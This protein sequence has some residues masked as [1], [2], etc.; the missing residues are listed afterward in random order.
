MYIEW[1]F[2]YK[3][4]EV[5]EVLP[6]F[7]RCQKTHTAHITWSSQWATTAV[8]LATGECSTLGEPDREAVTNSLSAAES[9]LYDKQNETRDMTMTLQC[10]P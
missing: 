5:W 6:S 9:T 7:C 1:R 10:M 4:R 2:N 3:L 8:T